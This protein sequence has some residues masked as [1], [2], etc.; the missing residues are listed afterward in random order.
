MRLDKVLR[1]VTIAFAVGAFI[2]LICGLAFGGSDDKGTSPATS[3]NNNGGPGVTGG[4]PATSVT[5]GEPVTAEKAQAIGSNELGQVLVLVYYEIGSEEDETTRTPGH[6]RDDLS[7]LRDEGFFPVNARD[8]VAGNLNVPAGQTPVVITFDA[9]SPGQY[10]IL[11]DGS[12]DP[13]CAVGILQKAAES[14][15][16]APRATFF[17]LTDVVP[18]DNELFGQPDVPREKLR[19]LVAWGY[20]VGSNTASRLDLSKA[21]DEEIADELARSQDTLE[22]M[23][24][25]GYSVTSLSLPYGKYPG[26]EE[27]L[28]EG[29][30]GDLTYTYTAVFA[31]DEVLAPSPFSTKSEPLRIPRITAT[32]QSIAD[33]IKTFRAHPELRYISDGDPTAVSAPAEAAEQLGVAR[34]DLGRPV[35]LY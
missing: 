26:S 5:V 18:S 3:D 31:L 20:E 9:S 27:L 2:G 10:R 12:L 23:I 11:D 35:I 25:G 4:V 29:E 7:L 14:D 30:S 15:D 19:N 32:A 8:F 33:A 13:D 28:A 24:G 6:L 21:D 17:C 22:E 16:W 34:G 1:F